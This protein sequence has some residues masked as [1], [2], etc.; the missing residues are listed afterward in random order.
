MAAPTGMHPRAHTLSRDQDRTD[1]A[2]APPLSD[3]DFPKPDLSFD[4]EGGFGAALTLRQWAIIFSTLLLLTVML[5]SSFALLAISGKMNFEKL[6]DEPTRRLIHAA[7]PHSSGVSSAFNSLPHV[8]LQY[9]GH[10]GAFAPVFHSHLLNVIIPSPFPVHIYLH[11]QSDLQQLPAGWDEEQAFSFASSIRTLSDLISYQLTKHPMVL[12]DFGVQSFL[13]T[14]QFYESITTLHGAEV[15]VCDLFIHDGI[16]LEY[17]A[18]PSSMKKYGDP[19]V[20]EQYY[21]CP[22]GD[23]TSY[24]AVHADESISA[25]RRRRSALLGVQYEWVV[26]MPMSVVFPMNVWEDVFFILPV[27]QAESWAKSQGVQLH[28][29]EGPLRS[30]ETL[31]TGT[32]Y[33]LHDQLYSPTLINSAIATLHGM[34]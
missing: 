3:T 9:A 20:V 27:I 29:L 24:W 30:N 1:I 13:A 5:V 15:R 2:S 10:V 18:L 12:A 21:D 6:D 34:M 8:A 7:Q 31:P 22:G 16:R 25:A 33:R 28:V 23:H 32:F 17:T 11:L 26:R 19:A 14:V 4:V